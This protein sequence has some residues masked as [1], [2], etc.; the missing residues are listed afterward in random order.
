MPFDP[1]DTEAKAAIKTAV[2]AAMADV[3]AKHEADIAGLK[4]KN[5]EL[6]A[7]NRTLKRGAEI[8]PEDLA[9]AED[10]ADKAEHALADAAKSVK[11]ITTER[12]KAV[13]SLE[14]EG[15]FTRKLLVENGLREALAAQG[16]TNAVHQKAAMA[17]LAGG[18]EIATDGDNRVAK[19]G[20]KALADFVKE[21]AGGEEGKH[22]VA[23][24][25]NS[26]GGAPG[27]RPGASAD[28]T[29]SRAAFDGL[30]QAER[31]TFAKDGG[32]VVDQAA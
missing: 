11:A 28:K 25:G 32:R 3:N 23:A 21:W 30:G 5:A 16:V 1:N 17:M 10:R 4:T 31:A 29:I 9:A 13:K 6:I 15:G 2:E 14:T 19:V 18:V 7:D 26:G 27:G 20:D 8:K 24:P 22:F 12:D